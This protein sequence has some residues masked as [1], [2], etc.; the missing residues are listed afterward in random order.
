MYVPK[1]W[2]WV[3]AVVVPLAVAI[4]GIV[5]NPWK[6]GGRDV[7]YVAGT[8]FAGDVAF[9]N[10]S[11]VVEQAQQESGEELPESVLKTLRQAADLIKSR[12]FERAIPLLKSAE[13]VAPVPALRGN[14]GAAYLA[15]GDTETANRYFQ[16]APNEEAARFNLTQVSRVDD[17]KTRKAPPSSSPARISTQ[18]AG[19]SVELIDLSRFQN[20]VTVKFRLINSSEEDRQFS[21][22]SD[23]FG[24]ESSYLLDEATDKKY[25]GTARASRYVTVPVGGTVEFW[26][27]YPLPEE[28]RSQYLTTV[29][30]YGILFEHVEVR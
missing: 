12:K 19:I 4:I 27:K 30:N 6:D 11:V 7:F 24:S 18:L 14:L 22:S 20:T 26:V 17:Q 29:F 8:Q 15:I 25:T 13:E 23:V 2:W 9:N 16:Q 28:E 5:G 10:V 21:P 3:V 1:K